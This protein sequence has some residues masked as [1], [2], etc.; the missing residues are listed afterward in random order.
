MD[1]TPLVSLWRQLPQRFAARCAAASWN[2]P[3]QLIALTA[4]SRLKGPD[5]SRYRMGLI[6]QTSAGDFADVWMRP[7]SGSL[8]A[9][10]RRPAGLPS[11]QLSQ[12]SYIPFLYGQGLEKWI[13]LPEARAMGARW[14]GGGKKLYGLNFYRRLTATL[15]SLLQEA[16]R[17]PLVVC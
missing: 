10:R 8:L 12:G 7:H 9:R 2:F 17:P 5:Q 14:A 4:P 3:S 13:R 15:P 1:T 11:G 6:G 16:F